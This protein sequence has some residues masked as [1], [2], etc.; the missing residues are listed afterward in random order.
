MLLVSLLWS[1]AGVVTRLLE[2][3]RSFEVTFWRSFFTLLALAVYLALTSG[4]AVPAL[5]RAGGRALLVSG[6]M[7]SLMFTCFMLALTLTSVANV[8]I[9]MSLAPLFTAL[10]ARMLLG[11]QVALR[12]WVSIVLAGAGIA[13]MYVHKISAEP[14]A[15]LGTLV[16]LCV[17]LAGAINWVTLQRNNG[18]G[19]R[20]G[21]NV[22][23]MPALLI[24]ALLSCLIS[25]P[26]ALPMQASLHDIGLLAG[27]GVF[28]LA[29][30]CVLAVRVARGLSAPEL[31]LLSLLEVVFGIAWAWLG[32]GEQPLPQVLAG[33]SLVL[34]TLAVNEGIGLLKKRAQGA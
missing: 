31:A 11:A 18:D 17:P 15:L 24:G 34:A 1:T 2:S 4:R 10:L 9:T 14:E 30:P 28:Q 13:W 22:D 32:A 23:L 3:A 6:V 25:L 19:S 16:A 5:F 26:F 20:A 8:L 12:T 27:L 7:W 29:L 33:G 21:R